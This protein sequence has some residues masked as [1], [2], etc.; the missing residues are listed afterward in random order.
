MRGQDILHDQTQKGQR[1]FVEKYQKLAA[2]H[3]DSLQYQY[4]FS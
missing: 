2:S 1:A 4:L 3:L